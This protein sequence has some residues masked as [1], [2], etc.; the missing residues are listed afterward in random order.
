MTTKTRTT[1]K[2][3]T[4][5]ASKDLTRLD[6]VVP[7]SPIG[8]GRQK[9]SKN[10]STLFKMAL[11]DGLEDMLLDRG[12]EILQIIMDQ[13]VDGCRTSQKMVMDRLMPAMKSEDSASKGGSQNEFHITIGRLEDTPEVKRIQGEVIDAD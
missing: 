10:K 1:A 7:H 5:G 2:K 8:K 4:S 11:R 12:Q 6:K 13:A 9:G 3:S